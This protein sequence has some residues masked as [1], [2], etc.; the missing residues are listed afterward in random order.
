MKKEFINPE[1]EIILFDEA[2]MITASGDL[3]RASLESVD[4]PSGIA[5]NSLEN[6]GVSGADMTIIEAKTLK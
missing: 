5:E 6:N 4:T 1:V 2:D 3:N